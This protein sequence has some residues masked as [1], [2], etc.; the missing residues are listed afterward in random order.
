MGDVKVEQKML[1]D[2]PSRVG[3]SGISKIKLRFLIFCKSPNHAADS[4]WAYTT[5]LSIALLRFCNKSGHIFN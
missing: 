1:S 2:F 4:E 3:S 5:P